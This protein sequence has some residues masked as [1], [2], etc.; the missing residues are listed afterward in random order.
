MEVRTQSLN[1]TTHFYSPNERL[2]SMLLNNERPC[3]RSIAFFFKT[4][5]KRICV[6]CRRRYVLSLQQKKGRFTVEKVRIDRFGTKKHI[7]HLGKGP[8]KLEK[9]EETKREKERKRKEQS[10]EERR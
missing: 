1:V 5:E 4:H 2:V 10:G 8:W 9:N 7:I 3:V 6:Q